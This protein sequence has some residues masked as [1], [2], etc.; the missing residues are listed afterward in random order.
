MGL[1]SNLLSNINETKY[2]VLIKRKS[3]LLEVN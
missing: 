2:A 3:N 1:V